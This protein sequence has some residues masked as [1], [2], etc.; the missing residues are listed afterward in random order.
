MGIKWFQLFAVWGCSSL[1]RWAQALH[2]PLSIWVEKVLGSIAL[3][4]VA[5]L[6]GAEYPVTSHPPFTFAFEFD[7]DLSPGSSLSFPRLLNPLCP[8]VALELTS[9][10]PQLLS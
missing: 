9:L 4:S 6:P 10:R 3:A 5:L 8:L 7:L 2:A 1:L